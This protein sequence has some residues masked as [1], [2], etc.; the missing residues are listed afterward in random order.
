MNKSFSSLLL[1][2]LL[3]VTAGSALAQEGATASPV[4]PVVQVAT[5][6]PQTPVMSHEVAS[7]MQTLQKA[8][9]QYR[10]SG[11]S[12]DLA[13]VEAVRRELASR[14]FGRI[15]RPAPVMM[16]QTQSANPMAGEQVVRVSVAE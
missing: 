7:L 6:N 11:N 15:T 10:R 2:L 1:T 16:A 8:Q 9:A 14:G 3:A 5:A 4:Q 13:R 12:Q